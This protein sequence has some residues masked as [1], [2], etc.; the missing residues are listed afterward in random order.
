LVGNI[1]MVDNSSDM[2]TCTKTDIQREHEKCER[3]S[4]SIS[5]YRRNLDG[6]YRVILNESI[7]QHRQQAHNKSELPNRVPAL[8]NPPE[9]TIKRR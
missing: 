6:F 1:L 3:G 8:E 9:N 7:L 5:F 4:F 2:M